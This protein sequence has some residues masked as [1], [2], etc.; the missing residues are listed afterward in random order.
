MPD[1]EQGSCQGRMSHQQPLN[2]HNFA[3]TELEEHHIKKILDMNGIP[4][5][6]SGDPPLQQPFGDYTE[7]KKT[8][9]QW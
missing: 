6:L 7:V 2:Y 9:V 5:L 4:S 3:V 1:S 8:T